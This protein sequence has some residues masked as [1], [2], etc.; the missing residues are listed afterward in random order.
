M[1]TREPLSLF[2]INGYAGQA[3]TKQGKQTGDRES[4]GGVV[5]IKPRS[6]GQ[7]EATSEN[8]N[9]GRH[10]H[11]QRWNRNGRQAH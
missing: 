4:D 6:G 1:A 10:S 5:S 9:S 2:E 8:L 7:Q 11:A 3:K